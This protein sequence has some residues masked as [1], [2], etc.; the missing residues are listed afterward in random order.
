M[1]KKVLYVFMSLVQFPSPKNFSIDV[2]LSLV[3]KTKQKYVL[4]LLDDLT[5]IIINFDL[6]MSKWE[7]DIFALGVIF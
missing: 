5:I 3:K 4:P 2:Q 1:V 6:E 7:H